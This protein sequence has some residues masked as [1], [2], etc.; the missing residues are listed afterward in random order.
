MNRADFSVG[1]MGLLDVK[2]DFEACGRH[3]RVPQTLRA[4]EIQKDIFNRPYTHSETG[5]LVQQTVQI[6]VR[7]ALTI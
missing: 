7:F 2:T 1:S 3:I 5:G 6:V 4:S